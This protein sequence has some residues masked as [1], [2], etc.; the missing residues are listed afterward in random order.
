M[1]SSS[2]TRAFLSFV[3][4]PWYPNNNLNFVGSS[5]V[6]VSCSTLCVHTTVR[7]QGRQF[8][9]FNPWYPSD[10]LVL[11][12]QVPCSTLYG[13]DTSMEP[14]FYSL[15]P[16]SFSDHVR[17]TPLILVVATVRYQGACPP[18]LPNRLFIVTSRYCAE[19][20][21]TK[22]SFFTIAEIPA[23]SYV[24]VFLRQRSSPSLLLDSIYAGQG[25][26][27]SPNLHISL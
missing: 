3:F 15:S 23:R 4:S 9:L 24:I 8:V 7:A 21:T 16:T 22:P 27:S 10:H 12:V 2:G 20:K 5:Q 14:P 6:Q 11:W 25:K 17:C 18:C 19:G 1:A 26:S 13:H